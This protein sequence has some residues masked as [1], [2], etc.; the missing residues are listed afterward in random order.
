MF[1]FVDEMLVQTRDPL[2]CTSFNYIN[3]VLACLFSAHTSVKDYSG[4][5]TPVFKKLPKIHFYQFHLFY[6]KFQHF[7]PFSNVY[8][9]PILIF[10]KPKFIEKEEDYL[11]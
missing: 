9:F 3:F 7:H 4:L 2:V 6:E 11:L 1:G 8:E 10:S 5:T